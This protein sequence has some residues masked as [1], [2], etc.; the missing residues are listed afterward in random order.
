MTGLALRTVDERRQ[1]L[2]ARH[3]PWQARTLNQHLDRVAGAHSDRPFV[4]GEHSIYTYAEMAQW[5][6][7]LARGL[8]THGIEPGERVATFLPNGPEFIAARFAIARA[9]AVCVP[10]NIRLHAHEKAEILVQSRAAGLLASEGFRDIDGVKVL[11]ELAPGWDEP[12]TPRRA[13]GPATEGPQDLRLIA[14]CPEPGTSRRR[15]S[16][17]SIADLEQ[18]SDPLIDRELDRREAAASP[19]DLATI[20]FTSGTTGVPK[21]VLS[22][23]DMELR[24]AYGSAFT[25]AFEDGRRILFA[26]PLNHVFAYI[27]GL[28]ASTFVAG[29]IVVQSAFDPVA[30]LRAVERHRPGEALFVPTMS[31]AVV[32]AARRGNPDTGSANYDVSSL[33]TVMSAAQSAPAKLWRD[34]FEALQL[35]TCITAYG[36]TETSAATTFTDPDAPIE[37]L[38]ETVGKPKPGGIAGDPA[39]GGL[40][41]EYKAVDPVTLEDVAPGESGELVA[42]GPIVASGYFE[43]P[44]ETA[45]ATL[46]GGWLRSGDLGFVRADGALVL[47]GRSKELYK[48]GGELVM[49]TEV[50]ARLTARPDVA[51]AYV[52]GVPDR[53]MGEVGCAWV[54]PEGSSPDPEE[55]I[56]YCRTE[57]ARFKV[58]AYVLFADAGSLPLTTSGKVQKYKLAAQA[59][60]MLG[61]EH[62]VDADEVESSDGDR[63]ASSA[64]G[65]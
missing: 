18:D 39:L 63:R 56:A 10:V 55:L 15:P 30:T 64:P 49:P 54:V 19:A 52:V 3:R 60:A 57:L 32:E 35:D 65:S 33:H 23:H 58:P 62:S 2:E 11:D 48:C 20:F 34:L 44:M 42:R 40:L 53:R 27:E 16:S 47:T 8:I 61:L 28:L 50:E 24:S 59:V 41:V 51:Q 43:R 9:G 12:A 31:L 29:S 46:P 22:T 4:V 6:R 5:S 17:L 1:Q 26:L 38:V 7:R 21:G 36:M 14:V 25:R 45:E 13:Y 37:D